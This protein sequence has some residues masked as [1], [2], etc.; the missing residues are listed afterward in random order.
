MRHE[1]HTCTYENIH[2]W[3]AKSMEKVEVEDVPGLVL[4]QGPA[5]CPFSISARPKD[6]QVPRSLQ[7]R[8]LYAEMPQGFQV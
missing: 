2:G 3:D 4:L 5:H 1:S 6:M 7:S 8:S